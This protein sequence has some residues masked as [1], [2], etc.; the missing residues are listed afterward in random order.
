MDFVKS[1]G[2]GINLGNTL[3]ACGDWIS[4]DDLSNYETAWGSPVITEDIIKGYK[5]MGFGVIRIPV[6]WSNMMGENYTINPD[7]IERVKTVAGWVLKHDMKAIVNIHYDNGW[8]GKFGTEKEECMKRYESFWTQICEAFKDY[9]LDLMFESLNEDGGWSDIWNRYGGST[10]GKAESYDLLREV[11]QKFVDIVRASGGNN[12]DRHLLIAGYCTDVYNTCD[13]MFVMPDDPKNRCAVS[14][15]YYTPGTFALLTEDASW[16][17]AR[18]DWG[19][20]EDYK[21]LNDMLDLVYERFIKNGVPVIIGEYGC[22][23][24]NKDYESVREYTSAVCEAIYTRSMCPV[25][26]D[27]VSSGFYDRHTI[28]PLRPDIIS[29]FAEIVKLERR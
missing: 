29:D 20:E 5:D 6:S 24:G 26:W 28:E 2:V 18:Y 16:G 21:E 23:A 12:A 25:L 22:A 13:E 11:N 1:M 8:L 27:T 9:S 17:K 7:L 10:N 14:I 15:H 4:A 3:E 19:T